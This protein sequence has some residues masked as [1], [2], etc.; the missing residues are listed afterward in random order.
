MRYLLLS[1]TLLFSSLSAIEISSEVQ[2]H[3]KKFATTA[4]SVKEIKVGEDKQAFSYKLDGDYVRAYLLSEKP[5]T[6]FHHVIVMV[7][8]DGSYETSLLPTADPY[9]KMIEPKLESLLSGEVDNVTGATIS[10][11]NIL[12][13]SELLKEFDKANYSK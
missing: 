3:F 5:F 10:T 13:N 11:K 12:K 7:K 9:Q 8:K 1:I 2:S 6:E 4:K